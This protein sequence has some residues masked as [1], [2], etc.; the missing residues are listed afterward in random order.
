MRADEEGSEEEEVQD[1]L[2][3]GVGDSFGCD[4][5]N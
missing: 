4:W 3:I 1:K 2:S 5:L